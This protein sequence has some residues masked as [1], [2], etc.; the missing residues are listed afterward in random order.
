[1]VAD[2]MQLLA[3]SPHLLALSLPDV[4]LECGEKPTDLP[5][6]NGFNG[7]NSSNGSIGMSA[8]SGLGRKGSEAIIGG[9]GG[10]EASPRNAFTRCLL[11]HL[12]INATWRRLGLDFRCLAVVPVTLLDLKNVSGASTARN[13]V[14]SNQQPPPYLNLLLKLQ[15]QR[16][17]PSI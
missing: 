2:G 4:E 14:Q 12:C 17:S 7:S 11:R 3:N 1:M 10:A 6:T 16:L 9:G 5:R 8:G 13:E 15:P